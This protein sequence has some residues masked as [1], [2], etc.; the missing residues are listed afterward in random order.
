MVGCSS[1]GSES[2]E[3][4]TRDRAAEYALEA[5]AEDPWS[6]EPP[7]EGSSQD[8][9]DDYENRRV[10][11]LE[12][13]WMNTAIAGATAA[14]LDPVYRPLADAL[15]GRYSASVAEQIGEGS[16]ITRFEWEVAVLAE[17]GAVDAIHGVD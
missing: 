12:E 5:C 17:C 2:A 7:S 13:W 14:Q 4:S 6:E 8:K 9:R 10:E 1:G 11:A 16:Q 3:Q 15:V